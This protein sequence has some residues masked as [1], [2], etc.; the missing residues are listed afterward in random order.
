MFDVG[1]KLRLFLPALVIFLT[2]QAE[3]YNSNA[4]NGLVC[5]RTTYSRSQFDEREIQTVIIEGVNLQDKNSLIP[6]PHEPFSSY[7]KRMAIYWRRTNPGLLNALRRPPNDWS[8]SHRE[9]GSFYSEITVATDPK[10]IEITF[11]IVEP[12]ITN[13][14]GWAYLS[15]YSHQIKTLMALKAFLLDA[16]SDT[17]LNQ[18]LKKNSPQHKDK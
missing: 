7:G 16:Q 12:K 14:S 6:G 9:F 11:A 13:L 1:M 8:L 3:A 17:P 2:N 18:L 10:C 15:K 5:Y 4:I